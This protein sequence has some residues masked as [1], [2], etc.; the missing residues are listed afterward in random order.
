MDV[1][2]LPVTQALLWA[3][4]LA[5]ERSTNGAILP[6]S[7]REK[8]IAQP[9]L[10]EIF[11]RLQF[12]EN[13]GLGYLTVDR[14][15]R[16]L[17]GGEA[18]RIRL[19]TQIGSGLTGV[20]YVCDEPTI[21][22]HPFD[23]NRLIGTLNHLRDLGNT[24]I[25][26]EHD[27]AIMRAANFIVDLGPRRRRARRQRGRHRHYRRRHVFRQVPDRPLPQRTQDHSGAGGSTGR[28]RRSPAR[29]R[30]LAKTT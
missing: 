17:S 4:G 3:N 6:L 7:A 12:L 29:S 1:C 26:V 24:V 2:A 8:A 14:S 19:A 15:A 25:V 27:E 30:A 5:S 10:K 18:Q 9:I 21:G 20:L 11:T 16:T 13:I 22:L 23:D 28:Q